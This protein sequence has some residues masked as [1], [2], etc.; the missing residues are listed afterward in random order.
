MARLAGCDQ[1]LHELGRPRGRSVGLTEL[2]YFVQLAHARFLIDAPEREA[3]LQQNSETG[4]SIG[5]G[6]IGCVAQL[7]VVDE[8]GLRAADIVLRHEI[9]R[10]QWLDVVRIGRWIELADQ[11]Q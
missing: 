1:Q 5:G 9:R 3:D 6:G 2:R 7:D 4:A 10:L 8:I 11:G